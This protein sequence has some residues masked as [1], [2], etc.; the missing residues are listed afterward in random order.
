MWRSAAA[1]APGLRPLAA[2][3]RGLTSTARMV[4]DLIAELPASRCPWHG[5]GCSGRH[6]STTPPSTDYAFEM[7]SSTI[8]FGE[9]VTAEVGADLALL[10]AKRV[11]V[12]SD[13]AIAALPNGPLARVLASMARAGLSP[14]VYTAVGVEPTDSTLAAAI[15][16]A[17]AY[18]ADA[19][20]AVG[21][22]SVM[23]TA[24]AANLYASHPSAA[25]LDFV[26]APIGRGLP[27]PGPVKPLIAI[28]TTAGTGSE[29][30]GVSIFDL[31]AANAK[32]GIASRIIKPTLGLV[33]PQNTASCPPSVAAAAGFDV[34]CH[35]LESYTALPYS[36]RSPRPPS[37]ALRP[38]YQGANPLSD[39]WSTYALRLIA[40]YFVRSV[41]DR[42]DS[43][44]NAA[45]TLAATS[46]GIGFG[47]AGVHLAHGMSYAISGLNRTYVHPGY[48][49]LGKPLVPHG[50][51][52]VLG[53]PAVFRRTAHTNPA[54]H[55]EAARIL[56]G[57]N[58]PVTV[59]LGGGGAASGAC[60]R[61]DAD[62]LDAG[63]R[64]A[65]Q[66]QRYMLA[67][68]VPNGLGSMGFE[69]AQVEG[70]VEATLPQRR[71]LALAP[72]EDC[73]SAQAL[74]EMFCE[75]FTV[76]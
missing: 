6:A 47:S 36:S 37:P 27:V 23:D 25:F 12:F 30:T 18:G 7:A 54:R 41:Q 46:A 42:G 11:M 1:A 64:L 62:A 14:H 68:N 55:A 33:D 40:K 53:A 29:T 9:G 76:Y 15:A 63:A 56:A 75:S 48:E 44:A 58:P 5:A 65:E 43:E 32:T 16:E 57:E 35:A 31:T 13:E 8:R 52:V 10:R 74:A 50:I 19:Y 73:A 61:S 34:L 67:L 69:R 4:R 20:V 3:A 45:M 28:P 59:A 60:A 38:A 51:S 71:V 72:S 17:K 22:G 66:L 2:H 21:G 39:V 49:R 26:N 70:M 24:K